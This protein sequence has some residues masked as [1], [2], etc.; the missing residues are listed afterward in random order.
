VYACIL[1]CFA[2]RRMIVHGFSCRVVVTIKYQA[3][4]T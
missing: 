2:L 4:S 3:V 1:V